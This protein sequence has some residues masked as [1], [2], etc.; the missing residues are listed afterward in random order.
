MIKEKERREKARALFARYREEHPE[1]EAR[2]QQATD[3]NAWDLWTP[4]D[5]EDD[6]W[7]K[8]TPNNPAFKAMEA[9][10]DK[11]HARQ[12]AQRQL[13]YRK[14]EEGNGL[15]KAGQYAE[16]LKTYEA[17]LEADKRSIE[18]HGN[19]AMAALKSGCFVQAIEHCD[20]ANEIAEFLLEQPAHPTAV[21]C[22]QRRATARLALRHFKDAMSDLEKAHLLDPASKE[23]AKQL[24]AAKAEYE[25]ARKEKEVE[26][27][28]RKA[29]SGK[30]GDVDGTDYSVLREVEAIMK[31]LDAAPTAEGD[32]VPV[33]DY[34]RLEKLLESSEQ[35]RVFLRAGGGVGLSKLQREMAEA[36]AAV[37]GWS[38]VSAGPAAAEAK[39][40]A[41]AAGRALGPAR[42][43][44]AACLSAANCECLAKSG[45]LE[46]AVRFMTATWCAT[47]GGA[48]PGAPRGAASKAAAAAAFLLHT[49]SA[50]DAPRRRIAAA[51][52]A[53]VSPQ[54]P[55]AAVLGM[56]SDADRVAA[57]HAL[58][59]LGNCALESKTKAALRSFGE[60]GGGG[61]DAWG[62]ATVPGLVAPLLR[63]ESMTLA[64][65]AAALL[66]N[67]CGEPALR[68]QLARDAAAVGDLVGLLAKA[69]T[70]EEK[71][72]RTP[73]GLGA[74]LAARRGKTAADG[75]S[76]PALR[77]EN[78]AMTLSA[79]AA[80]SN[81]LLEESAR[82]AAFEAK[83]VHR[84]LPLLGVTRP[85]AIAA[86]AVTALSRLAREPG[87]AAAL[88]AAPA[89]A[90][91]ARFVEARLA[92]GTSG[93]TSDDTS[94]AAEGAGALE[95]GV[96]TLA[97][98]IAT[99]DADT[100]ARLCGC[101]GG[102]LVACL[103]SEGASDGVVGNAALA[104]AD[105]AKEA[106]LLPRLAELEPVSRLLKVCRARTGAAQKNA[107]IACARLAHHP[108]MLETLKESNGL[109]LI[110]R[111]VRP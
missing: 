1:D 70:T 88:A 65:R 30:S 87:S 3:Y 67:L 20:K 27:G 4:S 44:R 36:T 96:R 43:L 21:K 89:A 94:D 85:A 47:S 46:I 60:R 42:A 72:K 49:C 57:A 104:V 68:Y 33:V 69:T 71:E 64:E 79:L 12:V 93:T 2:R 50:A 62:G 78:E 77:V 31:T 84:L 40:A 38:T 59:L 101:A 23:I 86:R 35:C 48:K 8:Y 14:R 51:L 92:A 76:P 102:A 75:S 90:S 97:V 32:V 6:P 63:D 26:R 106:A 39:A 74:G 55:L 18:L 108:P 80:L 100:R 105:L 81:V 91:V 98:L 41:A 24:A 34:A 110:Y 7:M 22:L 28:M 15:F 61:H 19:A 58:S 109:E 9:D 99:A 95:A 5:D 52:A 45:G 10:I 37:S 11:R 73:A 29:A 107:A 54:G 56:L 103:A 83:A 53:D 13:A 66:G 17:G 111:Y 16:A 82:S 25:E